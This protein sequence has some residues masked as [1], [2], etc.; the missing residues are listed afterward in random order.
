MITTTAEFRRH[1]PELWSLF[2][3]GVGKR[4]H[5]RAGLCCAV[6]GVRVVDVTLTADDADI[7]LESNS[8]PPDWCWLS[9]GKPLTAVALG[10][11]SGRSQP[12]FHWNDPV[13]RWLPALDRPATAS[14]TVRHLLTHT[15]GWP[16]VETGW[17]DLDWS[18]SIERVAGTDPSAAPGTVAAYQPAA[19]WFLLGEVLQQ[20]TGDRYAVAMQ[21][22]VLHPWGLTR[23]RVASHTD[24]ARIV[25]PLWERAGAELQPLSWHLPPRTERPSPGSS[26][27]G[28]LHELV[29][30]YECF[31]RVLLGDD[32]PDSSLTAAAARE[33][34]RPQR[35]GLFDQTLQHFVDFGLG[36]LLNS[37]RYGAETVPYGYGTG[38]SDR[39][40]GHG[41]AQ[42]S[43]GWT[44]PEH[45][46]TVAYAFDGRPGE[47]QHQ[48]RIR[49]WNDAIWREIPRLAR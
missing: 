40:F 23:C 1:C 11:L 46:L 48:R 2:Q 32:P 38:A 12:L 42:S 20:L 21:R 33:L 15:S 5:R 4:L 41:G 31:R 35:V 49:A 22:L 26:W 13:C 28:P 6:D 18:A 8:S 39:T 10:A 14:I 36:L 44:D 37:Q 47:G 45:N 34:V 24:E 19:T 43:Q 25:V 9:A 30:F 17:P 16:L 29:Q 7:A 27:R 3:T